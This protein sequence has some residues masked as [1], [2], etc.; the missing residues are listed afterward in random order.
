MQE[1]KK[2]P[3]ITYG[4]VDWIRGSLVCVWLYMGKSVLS[5]S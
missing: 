3:R 1:H 5:V 4:G 2:I